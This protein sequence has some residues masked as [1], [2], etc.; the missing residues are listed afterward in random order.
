[1]QTEL[2]RLDLILH[3]DTRARYAEADG[4]TGVR[5]MEPG[6]PLH[7]GR[8]RRVAICCANLVNAIA[9]LKALGASGI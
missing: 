6:M 8:M 7:I 5:T 9:R 1:M 4:A 2:P 3:T